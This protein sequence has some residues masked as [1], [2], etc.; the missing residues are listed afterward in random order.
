MAC[1]VYPNLSAS[2][3]LDSC[4]AN[5]R[6][7]CL[8]ISLM[9]SEVGI[10]LYRLLTP[11]QGSVAIMEGALDMISS[12]ERGTYLETRELAITILL[13]MM[14]LYK[15]FIIRINFLPCPTNKY[16]LLKSFSIVNIFFSNFS[17][18]FFK[19]NKKRGYNTSALCASL[20]L[21]LIFSLS[22]NTGRKFSLRHK[23]L[24]FL[25]PAD[26][27]APVSSLS[28]GFSCQPHG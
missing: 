9:S 26:G 27:L 23:F 17:D 28:F 13:M 1:F 25:S 6:K 12:L 2:R 18:F 15:F 3:E 10:K 8:Y 7:S 20:F 19:Q 4:T 14:F 21:V 22:A 24:V 5:G 16:R 11:R